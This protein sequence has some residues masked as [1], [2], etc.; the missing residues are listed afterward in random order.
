MT[1]YVN[2]GCGN[3]YHPEWI[4]IDIIPYS[5]SIVVHDISQGIPLSNE[6]C[7]VVYHS[8][9]VEHIRRQD[10]SFFMRE[11]RR[12]LK[13][14]GILRVVTPDLERICRIYL[15]KLEETIAGKTRS[16]YDYNWILLEMYDQTVREQGGGEMLEYLRQNPLPNET[17]VYERIGEEGRNIVRGLRNVPTNLFQETFRW[18]EVFQ[19][20]RSLPKVVVKRIVGLLGRDGMRALTVGR[21]RLGGEV[22]HWMYDRYSLARLMMEA[23]FQNPIQQSAGSSQIS[24]WSRFNLDTLPDGTVIKPDS[25]FMEATKPSEVI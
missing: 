18:R 3:R 17:F 24:P 16:H 8:H 10:I 9:L 6:S 5:P 21:F 25:L 20:L 13:P 15:Q 1:K 22:H 19:R 14:G 11:C 4:N 12:V 23:G 2:L 7:D